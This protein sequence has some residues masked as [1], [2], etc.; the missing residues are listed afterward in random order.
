MS[1]FAKLLLVEDDYDL[2]DN[3]VD[4]LEIR[5]FSVIHAPNGA[6][7]LNELLE[8][9][10]DAILLDINL[11]GMNGLSLCEHIRNE[12]E[13]TTPVLMLTAA[14]TVEDRLKGFS[15]GT[16]D[17]VVKPFALP[18]VE[19]RI[20]ALLRRAGS[21]NNKGSN[22]LS[23]GDLN[24]DLGQ[25][26]ARINDRELTLTT[27]GFRILYQLARNAP[28]IVT[29]PDLEIALWKEEPP[30]SD[31]LRTHIFALRKELSQDSD[32]E[33]L[34]TIRGVGYQLVKN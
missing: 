31:A 30:G 32:V 16:D 22:V 14:D 18:E 5:G 4:Y 27:M 9:T 21:W 23:F 13:N 19:A 33:R 29:R 11:P 8:E 17:Y 1:T 7:A 2:A 3:M 12:M 28:N 15:A 20:T 6:L 25:M 24:L 34:K 10:F 26:K